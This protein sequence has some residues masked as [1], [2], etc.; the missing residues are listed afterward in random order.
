MVY[1]YGLGLRSFQPVRGCRLEIIELGERLSLLVLD[2]ITQLEY[3]SE[4]VE[5]FVV[6]LP[7]SLIGL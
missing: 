3:P 2:R 4:S 6:V 1:H 5:G 7:V